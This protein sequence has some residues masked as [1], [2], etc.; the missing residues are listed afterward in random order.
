MIFQ[1]NDY[2]TGYIDYRLLFASHN[3]CLYPSIIKTRLIASQAEHYEI[4]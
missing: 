3:Y 1:L 2:S 4:L